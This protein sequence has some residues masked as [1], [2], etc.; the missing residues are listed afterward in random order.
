MT[1]MTETTET[2]L[3]KRTTWT[4]PQHDSPYANSHVEI[5]KHAGSSL[6]TLENGTRQGSGA[7]QC[8][9]SQRIIDSIP[10]GFVRPSCRLQVSSSQFSPGGA[11]LF[12]LK[13]PRADNAQRGS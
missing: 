13:S 2:N 8:L 4:S 6:D 1:E 9:W 5:A 10:P 11:V 12:K 3:T 7:P